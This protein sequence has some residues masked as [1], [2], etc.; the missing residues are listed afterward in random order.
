M[1][2]VTVTPGGGGA[3]KEELTAGRQTSQDPVSTPC[4]VPL[5]MLSYT[6]AKVVPPPGSGQRGSSLSDH[7]LEW[8][9]KTENPGGD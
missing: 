8:T 3:G 9:L 7:D 1:A 5:H 6:I 2:V 4:S